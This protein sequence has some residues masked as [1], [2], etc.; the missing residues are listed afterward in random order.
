MRTSYVNVFV[1]F[2]FN[3]FYSYHC[4]YYFIMT[5]KKNVERHTHTYTGTRTR[6]RRQIR[7]QRASCV[8]SQQPWPDHDPTWPTFTMTNTTTTNSCNDNNDDD[9]DGFSSVVGGNILK[10]WH[11]SSCELQALYVSQRLF[12]LGQTNQDL[13]S[14]DDLNGEQNVNR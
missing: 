12:S 7:R 9:D 14:E 4:M 5:D 2:N 6:T 13:C 3:F 1:V 10:I 8:S 11:T